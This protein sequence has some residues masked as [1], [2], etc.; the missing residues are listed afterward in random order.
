MTNE[1]WVAE[2]G[3]VRMKKGVKR[4]WR[5]VEKSVHEL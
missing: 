5:H 3:K 1:H 2:D 4:Q